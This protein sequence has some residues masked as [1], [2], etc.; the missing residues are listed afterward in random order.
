MT[1]ERKRVHLRIH[2]H[3]QGVWFRESA[4][5]EAGRTGVVGWIRNTPEGEVEA[6][7]EGPTDAVE[8]FVRWCHRGPAAA[9]VA[10][11]DRVDAAPTGEFARFDVR[12]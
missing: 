6:V 1:D 8:A 2:G 9:R 4:R 12:R 3:V 7:A 5:Q 10:G 11:V